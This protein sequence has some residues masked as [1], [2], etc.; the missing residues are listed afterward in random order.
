MAQGVRERGAGNVRGDHPGKVKMP[1][2]MQT[3]G[4]TP[5]LGVQMQQPITTAMPMAA[6]AGVPNMLVQGAPHGQ[7][8]A[9]V[10]SWQPNA[11]FWGA[12]RLYGMRK[13]AAFQSGASIARKVMQK[14]APKP[15]VTPAMAKAQ[16]L[17]SAT[18][19]ARWRIF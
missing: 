13:S 16:E 19:T 6:G 2:F 17:V 15:S 12:I 18:K 7:T 3:S 1:N 14:S 4:I 8:T 9:K 5:P 10:A 11:S